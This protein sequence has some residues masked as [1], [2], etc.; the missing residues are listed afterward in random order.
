MRFIL[1]WK[2]VYPFCYVR[3]NRNNDNDNR[4]NNLQYL[5]YYYTTY[6]EN[7]A[8][9]FEKPEDVYKAWMH[10]PTHKENILYPSY[11][12]IGIAKYKTKDGVTYWAQEFGF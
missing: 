5:I 2:S 11:K 7:L 1:Y 8:F 9:N 10:S 12:T 4:G 6:G 3:S